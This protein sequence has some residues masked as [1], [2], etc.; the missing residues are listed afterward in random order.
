MVSLIL[1][2]RF[3]RTLSPNG[4]RTTAK[5][6]GEKLEDERTYPEDCGGMLLTRSAVVEIKTYPQLWGGEKTER[7]TVF[8]LV[9]Q[10]FTY[11]LVNGKI[12]RSV[13]SGD[14]R[15]R[16][17][18]SERRSAMSDYERRLSMSGNE[19]QRLAMS[20]SARDERRQVIRV[21]V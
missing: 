18:M 1:L 10:Y 4:S 20:G 6:K 15:K 7:G 8:K 11:K 16:S 14:E 21:S 12:T 17:V 9:D 19:R 3:N 13:M 2:A 5:R